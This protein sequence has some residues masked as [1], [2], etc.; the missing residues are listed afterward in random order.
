MGKA[1]ELFSYIGLGLAGVLALFVY[2]AM[3]RTDRK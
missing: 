3:R 1:I 2:G